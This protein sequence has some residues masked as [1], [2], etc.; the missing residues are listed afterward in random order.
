MV[1]NPDAKLADSVSTQNRVNGKTPPTFIVFSTDDD[2]VMVETGVLFMKR[3][4]KT[5]FR[6]HFTTLRSWRSR[7]WMWLLMIRVISAWP[8]MS[9]RL[10]KFITHY[11][12]VINV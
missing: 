2:V 12:L 11:S 3:C 7:I 5:I 4:I 8:K 10:D 1:P 6:Q 9:V